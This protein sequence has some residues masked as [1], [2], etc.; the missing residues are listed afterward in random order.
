MTHEITPEVEARAR[1]LC[2]A[3]NHDPDEPIALDETEEPVWRFF[4]GEAR[5]VLAEER[6]RSVA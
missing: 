3:S 6:V 4:V 2:L 1:A 5:E